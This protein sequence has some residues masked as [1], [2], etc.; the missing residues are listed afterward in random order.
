MDYKVFE[1]AELKQGFIHN[2][3]Q[4]IWLCWFLVIGER[5]NQDLNRSLQMSLLL[6]ADSGIILT[7]KTMEFDRV[8]L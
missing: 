4:I 3:P 8:D 1:Q 2:C 6:E 7:C 5:V